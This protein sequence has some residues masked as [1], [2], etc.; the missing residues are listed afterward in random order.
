MG[1]KESMNVPAKR[2]CSIRDIS[3]LGFS[4]KELLSYNG[5]PR[6]TVSNVITR[7]IE[8]QSTINVVQNQN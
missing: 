5:V 6:S 3:A 8:R 4:T 2:C 1:Q 7:K